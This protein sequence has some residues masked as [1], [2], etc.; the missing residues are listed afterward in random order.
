VHGGPQDEELRALGIQSAQLLDFSVSTNPYGPCPGVLEAIRAAPIDRYPD[1]TGRAVREV[2]AS[3]LGSA[4]DEIALGNGAAE[5]L[6]ALAR[7]LLRSGDGVLVVEPT[8]CEFRA[9]VRAVGARIAEWRA[10]PGDGFAIDLPAITRVMRAE[11]ARVVYLCAPNTPT[12]TTVAA[13]EIAAWAEDSPHVSIVLDQSFLSLSERF[14]DAAARMPANV[15]RVRSL[16]KEHAI[17]GV[18]LGYLLA[19]AGVVA[20]IEQQRPAWMTSTMAQA[21]AMAACRE[22]SFVDQSRQKILADR[23]RLACQVE[24]LGLSTVGSTTGFFLVRTAHATA[25]RRRLLVRHHILVRDCASF[26]LPDFVRLAAR[27]EPD[28]ERLVAALR[29]ERSSC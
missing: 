15:I 22:P 8:F 29:E 3:G 18:R 9:A 26:G 12:G 11:R 20:L 23:E 25:L 27:P 16:T 10:N 21:A 14:A 1:P 4:A 5:L 28:I 24:R 13:S 7:A 19:P 2:M 6:W 17:P